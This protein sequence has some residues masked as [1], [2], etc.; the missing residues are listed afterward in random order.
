[1]HRD[2]LPAIVFSFSRRE[3][4]EHPKALA[5]FNFTTEEE[6]ASVR[7]VYRQALEALPPEDR[8]LDAVTKILPLLERGIGIHHSGLLPVVKELVEILFGESL[9]KVLFATETFAM[10]L[11]MP[12][13][14]VVFTAH[15][16]FD[17]KETRQIMPGEYTQMSGRAGRRGKDPFGACVMMVDE[18]VDEDA[19][20]EMV[21]GE[22]RPLDSEFRLSYY[23]ILNLLKRASAEQDAEYVIQRSFHHFQHARNVPRWRRR[24]AEIDA[25]RAAVAEKQ[26]DGQAEYGGLLARAEALEA[27]TRSAWQR[28]AVSARFPQARAR[29]SRPGPA[30]ARTGV[31]APS[32]RSGASREGRDAAARTRRAIRRATTRRNRTPRTSFSTCRPRR[33]RQTRPARSRRL[34]PRSGGAGAARAGA[35][36]V[37][38]RR[39]RSRLWFRCRLR[40]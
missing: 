31:G 26:R 15:K 16:K 40:F 14:C 3:C 20:R 13:R 11:N 6:K 23:S 25:E 7:H 38:S 8:E 28:P 21:L 19:L 32:S 18:R 4:E 10:G 2:L 30:R 39:A 22:P 29:R 37:D 17:G 36:A 34:R 24:V 27:A 1:M 5:R 12:A 33:K 9:V 35:A